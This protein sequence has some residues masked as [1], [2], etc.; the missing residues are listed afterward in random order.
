MASY[1]NSPSKGLY[2]YPIILPL[3]SGTK[4]TSRIRSFIP[5]EL[6]TLSNIYSNILIL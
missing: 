4:N 3:I 1:T 6:F 5:R 2:L